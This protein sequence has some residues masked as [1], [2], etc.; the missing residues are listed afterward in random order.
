MTVARLNEIARV[1]RERKEREAYDEMYRFAFLASVVAT[2]NSRK[3]FRPEDFIGEPPGAARA[4]ER[5]LEAIRLRRCL[6]AARALG[7]SVPK[8]V[9]V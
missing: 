4:R 9:R 2:V 6:D 3:R 8:E 7:L 5:A 1:L